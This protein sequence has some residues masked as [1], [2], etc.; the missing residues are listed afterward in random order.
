MPAGKVALLS[1]GAVKGDTKLMITC[2]EYSNSEVPQSLHFRKVFR[3]AV[4]LRTENMPAAVPHG[5][6]FSPDMPSR[7]GRER[8]LGNPPRSSP[9]RVPF[10]KLQSLCV[11]L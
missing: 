11:S 7:A 9:S 10:R 3:V 6:R 8:D 2:I 4:K 5:G 1:Y